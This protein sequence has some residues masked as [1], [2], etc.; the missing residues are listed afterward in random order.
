M[1]LTSPKAEKGFTL[2][3]LLIIIGIIG[4]LAAAI[5]VAVDPVKRIQDARNAKRWSEVNAVLNAVL[6]KQVDSR[7][8]FT[9]SANYPI[10]NS[11]DAQLIINIPADTAGNA[12]L[13]NGVTPPTCAAHSLNLTGAATCYV[14]LGATSA[15]LIPTYLAD[16][17]V[18]PIGGTTYDNTDTGYYLLQADAG[19]RITIGSCEQEQSA[20]IKVTR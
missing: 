13:C 7:A 1:R 3:E 20:D 2:I 17:P 19:G 16:V 14:N 11:A 5:L 12:P 4:F 6:T 8:Y 9:G 15:G 10:V 18:D